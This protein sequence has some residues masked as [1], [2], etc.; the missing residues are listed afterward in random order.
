[1]P[2]VVRDDV[3]NTFTQRFKRKYSSREQVGM[4]VGHP[5]ALK[6]GAGFSCRSYN[7]RATTRCAKMFLLSLCAIS[8]NR[9]NCLEVWRNTAVSGS[10]G[11]GAFF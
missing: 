9:Q 1:M 8:R 3:S 10:P 5:E 6:K 11:M 4:V 7:A 2:S